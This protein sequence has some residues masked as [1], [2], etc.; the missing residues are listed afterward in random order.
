MRTRVIQDYPKP[1]SCDATRDA[2]HADERGRR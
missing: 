1:D 2:V